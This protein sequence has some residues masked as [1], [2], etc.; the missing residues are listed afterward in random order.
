V[1]KRSAVI[2]RPCRWLLRRCSWA[3]PPASSG[4]GHPPTGLPAFWSL[5]PLLL[6][7]D[8]SFASTAFDTA[9]QMMM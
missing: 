6:F 3:G 9:W 7:T 1:R 5:A 8:R 4:I 2:A